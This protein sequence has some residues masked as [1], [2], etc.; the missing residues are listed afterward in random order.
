M[1]ELLQSNSLLQKIYRAIS[2]IMVVFFLFNSTAF[3]KISAIDEKNE[4]SFEEKFISSNRAISAWFDGVADGIDL[5]LVGKRLTPTRN[6]TNVKIENATYS[7]E[8]TRA[9]N[10]TTLVV[11]PRF[12]NLE[13]YWSLKF[14]TYD[15][16]E[17]RGTERVYLRQTPRERNYGASVGLFRK[18][19][20]V[21]TV[22][23]PRIELQDPL[24]ISHSLAFE[25]VADF[26]TF[27]F[28]P[29]I[30]FFASAN[31]G[32]GIF[33]AFNFNFT[34]TDIWSLTLIN[35]AEYEDKLHKYSVTNGFSFGQD[36]SETD[37]MAYSWLFFSNNR[38]NYHLDAYSLSVTWYHL[39]YKKILDFKLTPHLDF[40]TASDYKGS[41]GTT[42][43][44][45]L[46]F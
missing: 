2:C 4:S 5:F 45:T 26:K 3:A 10:E 25:S 7:Q 35:E 44:I 18:F 9:I 38:D 23:Q 42:L 13:K 16:Q 32:V 36:I 41:L 15:E 33:H 39:L 22:F 1:P 21:R 31:K 19:G 34:L 8:G 30:E 43:Q 17:R 24:K 12:P 28:N 27:K 46:N 6:E 20:A 29:K 14:T 40:S 37:A 11:N